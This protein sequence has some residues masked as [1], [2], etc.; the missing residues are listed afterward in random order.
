MTLNAMKN[1]LKPISKRRAQ[2]SFVLALVLLA[3]MSYANAQE[4]TPLIVN[5]ESHSA[6]ILPPPGEA[7]LR[8][9]SPAGALSYHGGPVMLSATTYAIFWIPSSGLLQDGRTRTSMSA[10]YQLVQENLLAQY[11]GHGVDNNNTQYFQI[12]NGSTNYID[13]V[14]GLGGFYVDTS[15]YPASGCTDPFTGKNCISDAQIQAEIKKVMTLNGWT[16]GPNKMFLLFTSS[17]EG[18]CFGSYCAY[19]YYCGYHSYFTGSST[20]IYGNEPYGDP[21]YCQAPGTPSPNGDPAAD[22]A[23]TVASHELTEAITDPQ[24]NAW[25]V[26]DGHHTEIGD[27]CAYKYGANTWDGGQANQMWSGVFF[28]LQTEYDNHTSSCVQV[29]P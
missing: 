17:G 5:D 28:E 1:T 25:Y 27:L 10:H 4:L 24:L 8:Q 21:N 15:S 3:A 29:G 2:C 18:S 7:L 9:S 13:N 23:A 22:T 19:S 11:P 14:A 26:N 6:H 16:G 20:V 12:V